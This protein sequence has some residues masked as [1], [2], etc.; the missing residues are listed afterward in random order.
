MPLYSGSDFKN[1]NKTIVNE[2]Y[3][4]NIRGSSRTIMRGQCTQSYQ[5]LRLV[6]C[7]IQYA[8]EYLLSLVSIPSKVTGTLTPSHL[9][10]GA[11]R[12]LR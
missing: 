11:A 9:I 5:R 3:W 12:H 8:K 4:T 10:G 6:S 2:N 1:D 7:L